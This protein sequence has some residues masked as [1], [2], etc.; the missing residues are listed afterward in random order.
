MKM[1]K[2]GL[3]ALL[4]TLTIL[5]SMACYAIPPGCYSASLGQDTTFHVNNITL[6][7]GSHPNVGDIIYTSPAYTIQYQC[8]AGDY[9]A[10]TYRANLVSL[11]DFNVLRDQLRNAGLALRMLVNDGIWYSGQLINYTPFPF[12]D[13]IPAGQNSQVQS[14][15]IQLQIEVVSS[16]P[17]VVSVSLSPH[18]AFKIII[19][20]IPDQNYGLNINTSGFRLQSIPDCFGRVSISPTW[21]SLGHIYTDYPSSQH[22]P[23]QIPITITAG[24][25]IGCTGQF[26]DNYDILLSTTFSAPGQ[27]LTSAS[28]AVALTNGQG[29]PNGLALSLKDN[30]GNPLT[31]DSPSTFGNLTQSGGD[32]SR[33]YTAN[34][35]AIPG[36]ELKTGSF[37]ANV[38]V[39]IT[40]Q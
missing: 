23:R 7:S 15:R 18:T 24:Q 3:Q 26:S 2:R 14:V 1:L 30:A 25:N 40:Y 4:C 34:L 36:T 17:N 9:S 21:V 12:G 6:R 33:T 32:I 27:T 29:E 22:L 8:Q 5:T 16:P 20:G 28:Q 19:G 13:A 35:D 37:S 39:N 31:F 38:V 11:P 10:T